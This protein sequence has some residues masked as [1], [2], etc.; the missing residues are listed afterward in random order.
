MKS[1]RIGDIINLGL[2]LTEEA[3]AAEHPLKTAACPSIPEFEQL[4]TQETKWSLRRI[5]H[6]SG[7][8]YC[9]LMLSVFRRELPIKPW[10]EKLCEQLQRELK[11]LFEAKPRELQFGDAA[12]KKEEKSQL[13][14]LGT[15][16]ACVLWGDDVDQV[17]VEI[18]QKPT[19]GKDGRLSFGLR[20]PVSNFK[21][22]EMV[23]LTLL[24]APTGDPLGTPMLIPV[25][26]EEQLAFELPPELQVQ[27]KKRGG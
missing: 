13:P 24:T 22:G 26:K 3:E 18:T 19:I 27:V 20:V 16:P 1:M 10:W 12:P 8:R 11:S 4:V 25:G 6:T 23:E 9:R 15:I 14:A 7:C 5:L 21:K 2:S 17:S